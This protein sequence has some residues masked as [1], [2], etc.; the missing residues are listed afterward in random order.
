LTHNEKQGQMKWA[1]GAARSLKEAFDDYVSKEIGEMKEILIMLS[2]VNQEVDE[3]LKEVVT[4]E[5]DYLRVNDQLNV[6]L[7]SANRNKIKKIDFTK[8]DKRSQPYPQ[9]QVAFPKYE[10]KESSEVEELDIIVI[11]EAFA[12][13]GETEDMRQ[14]IDRLAR[15]YMRGVNDI[16]SVVDALLQKR[17]LSGDIT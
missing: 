1:V 5:N 11:L 16:E 12:V 8:S 2:S 17:G 14:K 9:T 13:V 7:D 3:E 6:V 15:N 4:L 10:H